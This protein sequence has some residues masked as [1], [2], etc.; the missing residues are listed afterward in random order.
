MV[1]VKAKFKTST[2]YGF[3]GSQRR[4]DGDVF[5]VDGRKIPSW[6]EKL[7]NSAKQQIPKQEKQEKEDVLAG[8]VAT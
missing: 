5:D 4:Y 8:N 6:C 3:Y 2:Q 7:P 1:M